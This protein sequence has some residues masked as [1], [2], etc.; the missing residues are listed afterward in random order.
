MGAVA[1]RLVAVVAAIVLFLEAVGIVVVNGI[2]ATVAG[3]QNMSLGGMDPGVM[4]TGTWVMGG[5]LGLFLA[6]CGVLL[7]VAGVRD[8]APGRFGRI[9]LVA[10]AVT[11]GV[12]GA[13]AVGLVGWEA[14]TFQM[15]VLGLLVLSLVAYGAV[16]PVVAGSDADRAPGGDGGA[17]VGEGPAPA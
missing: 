6:A 14:F 13:L 11:H 3:N 15:V 7:L 12:L 5:G 2:L 1:R 16:E 4:A 10:C 9:L 17:P 8:R